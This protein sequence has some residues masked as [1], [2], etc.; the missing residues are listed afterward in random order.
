[1][2][3]ENA[4]WLGYLVCLCAG[5]KWEL[6]DLSCRA[7]EYNMYLREVGII[8]CLNSSLTLCTEVGILTFCG[9]GMR[10]SVSLL[11]SLGERVQ[12]NCVV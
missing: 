4:G 12:L 10:L 2:G 11:F 3:N 1:M 6:W 5:E 7:E 8:R 9:A